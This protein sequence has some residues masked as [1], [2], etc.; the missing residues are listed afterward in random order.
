MRRRHIFYFLIILMVPVLLGCSLPGSSGKIPDDF[1][2]LENGDFSDGTTGW[3]LWANDSG[4]AGFTPN[5]PSVPWSQLDPVVWD[6]S[7]PLFEYFPKIGG[8]RKRYLKSDLLQYW[9]PNDN[10]AIYSSLSVS[11]TNRL[12]TVANFSHRPEDRNP[13]PD[14]SRA[15]DDHGSYGSHY[16]HGC[17][18]R[19][20]RIADPDVG[21]L[22]N[23]GTINTIV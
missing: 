3:T 10:D 5:D 22:W 16:R 7:C 18:V 23:G 21:R 17:A 1:N 2:L 9:V 20:R 13:F 6:Y 4:A 11:S 14:N 8:I 19:R 12:L 15:W